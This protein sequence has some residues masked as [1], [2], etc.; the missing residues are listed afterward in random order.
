MQCIYYTRSVS[1]DYATVK[2]IKHN[3]F[4]GGYIF[5]ILT[6][7]RN[8][9]EY[10]IYIFLHRSDVNVKVLL[11]ILRYVLLITARNYCKQY[12]QNTNQVFHDKQLSQ[13]SRSV[14]FMWKQLTICLVEWII[15]PGEALWLFCPW[16]GR[17]VCQSFRQVLSGPIGKNGNSMWG[18]WDCSYQLRN[19]RFNPRLEKLAIAHRF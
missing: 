3:S 16:W 19:Q 9:L 5:T 8:K 11:K 14:I 13:L 7:A 18:Q 12:H 6:E 4:L 15:L 10:K 17:Y 2:L 1:V